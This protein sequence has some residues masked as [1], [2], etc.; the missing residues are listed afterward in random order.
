MNKIL[1]VAIL[2]VMSFCFVLNGEENEKRSQL[3]RDFA[4]VYARSR[5]TA[6]QLRPITREIIE[7]FDQNRATNLT[8]AID[9]LISRLSNNGS[10]LPTYR[11]YREWV[12]NRWASVFGCCGERNDPAYQT[13]YPIEARLFDIATDRN[14]NEQDRLKAIEALEIM[15]RSGYSISSHH[16][17]I[18]LS[19]IDLPPTRVDEALTGLLQIR[20]PATRNAPAGSSTTGGDAPKHSSPAHGKIG[21]ASCRERV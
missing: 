7:Q 13:L 19:P 5:E 14:R 18:L 1:G 3:P 12:G 17:L 8:Q 10:P 21:R 15:V 4:S 9:V 11:Y 6:T 2:M 20:G 16:F